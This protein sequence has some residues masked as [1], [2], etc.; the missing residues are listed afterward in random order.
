MVV[1][2][3]GQVPETH[4]EW[5]EQFAELDLKDVFGAIGTGVNLRRHPEISYTMARDPLAESTRDWWAGDH[6]LHVDATRLDTQPV[7]TAIGCRRAE[8]GAPPTHL[9]DSVKLLN[10]TLEDGFWNRYGLNDNDLLDMKSVFVDSTYFREAQPFLKTFMSPEEQE[11]L[12]ATHT[13]DKKRWKADDLEGMLDN[14][15]DKHPPKEFDLIRKTPLSKVDS[16]FIDGG[17]RNSQILGPDGEDLTH[18]LHSLRWEYLTGDR[19]HQLG[20][21]KSIGW[22]ANKAVIFPQTGT[23]HKAG[24][25]NDYNRVLHLAF[26]TD[27]NPA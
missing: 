27:Q 16:L 10:M 1:L 2:E 14:M 19:P 18:V 12:E 4:D 24:A 13:T 5:S 8:P 23:L 11:R 21:L 26:L 9:V 17:G 22:T 15:D 6:L 20:L 7:L 25:G 3:V